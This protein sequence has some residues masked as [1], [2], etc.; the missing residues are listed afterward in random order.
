M[1]NWTRNIILVGLLLP[2]TSWGQQYTITTVAGGGSGSF[3]GVPATQAQVL[4]FGV[5]VDAAGNLYITQNY[6]GGASFVSEV[7]ANGIITTIAGSA[8]SAGFSGDGGPAINAQ[9]SF[10]LSAGIAVDSLGNIYIADAA[11][12]RVR[13]I[14]SNGVITTVAGGGS[15]ETPQYGDGGPATAAYLFIPTSVAVDS[16]GNLYISDNTAVRKVGSNGIITTVAGCTPAA[17]ACTEGYITTG[18]IGDGGPATSAYLISAAVAIDSAGN[19]YISDF[20]N[21]RIRKVS[22]SGTITTVAGSASGSYSGDGGPATSAG[23]NQPTGVAVDAAGN[24]YIDDAGD[25]RIRMVTPGGTISTIAGNGAE[26]QFGDTPGNGAATSSNMGPTLGIALGAGGIVYVAD[27]L[28]GVRLLKPAS[29]GAP[30]S[31]SPGG[32]VSAS[33]FGEFTSVA[34]GSWIEIYGSNLAP[35]TRAWTGS[36]F[37]GSN[38]PESLDGTSV[39]IGGLPAYV[40]FISPTQVN[41]QVPS[42][43]GA[44]VQPLVVTTKAGGA[45][46]SY[47]VTVDAEQPGLLAPSSFKVDGN[48]YVVALFPDN[49]TYV[50]P[51]DAVPGIASRPAQPGD[52]II[53]YGVGFGDVTPSI[54]AGELAGELNTLAAPFHVFFG[55]TEATLAYD[56]LAPGYVGLYQFNVVVPNVAGNALTPLTFTLGGTHGT[57]TLYIAVQ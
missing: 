25:Y 27:D 39:T 50:L 51:A 16:K 13:K 3:S 6:G 46:N 49:T 47:S 35:D 44:G 34:P 2:A 41:V 36:D 14:G 28:Y 52:T 15:L 8:G 23:L 53:L 32:V 1:T 54:P 7:T 24:I 21:N 38:A 43:V 4:P 20:A 22:A 31:V 55:T 56:G 12:N 29:S 10:G 18:S 40:A 45:G 30:P 17:V 9:F 57:Q 11:N 26:G 42:G 19:L 48:Q 33:A 5:A 37:N